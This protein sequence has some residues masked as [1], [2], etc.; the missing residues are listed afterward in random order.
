MIK[1]K[2]ARPSSFLNRTA[3]RFSAPLIGAMPFFMLQNYETIDFWKSLGYY[4][5]YLLGVAAIGATRS[6]R[7]RRKNPKL[8][9]RPYKK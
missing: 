7:P 5:L 8:Y 6:N 2:T 4:G 1:N 9:Y 3:D